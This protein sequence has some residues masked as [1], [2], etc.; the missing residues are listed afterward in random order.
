M[1]ALSLTHFLVFILLFIYWSLFVILDSNI[2]YLLSI[3]TI[4]FVILS[5]PRSLNTFFF[6]FMCQFTCLTQASFPNSR[7]TY[8]ANWLFHI[9]TWI[10]NIHFKQNIPKSELLTLPTWLTLITEFHVFFDDNSSYLFSQV[11]NLWVILLS[12]HK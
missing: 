4:P 9:S 12:Y 6:L 10:Y 7:W 2:F 3:N 1:I 5:S 8:P 11:N